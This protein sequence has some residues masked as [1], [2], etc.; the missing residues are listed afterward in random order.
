MFIVIRKYYIIAG[1]GE[2]WVQRVQGG[3][4]PLLYTV[5]GFLAH[6]D[7]EV[8]HDEVVSISLF[9]TQEAWEA[10]QPRTARW[11]LE[12]LTPLLQTFPE[13][14]AGQ[15]KASSHPLHRPQ[16]ADE[17]RNNQYWFA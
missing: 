13:I 12:Q 1:R 14:T 11:T 16:E 3:L 17:M 10:S 4:M 5:P 7:L 6:Y 2:E 9:E 15:V 8:R